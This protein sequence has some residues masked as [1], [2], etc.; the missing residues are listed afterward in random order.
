MQDKELIGRTRQLGV[1]FSFVVRDFHLV[2]AVQELHD[3][4]HLPA[5][6]MMRGDVGEKGDDIE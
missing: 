5:Y 3:G 6:E 4:T 2:G 1:R